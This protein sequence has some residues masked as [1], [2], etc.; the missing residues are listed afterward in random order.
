MYVRTVNRRL[1]C[2]CSVLACSS[3]RNVGDG[4]VSE[5][6]TINFDLGSVV[7]VQNFPRNMSSLKWKAFTIHIAS[8]T[9]ES[10]SFHCRFSVVIHVTL[11]SLYKGNANCMRWQLLGNE[12]RQ[13]H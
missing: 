13:Y 12:N 9:A 5:T 4:I 2:T 1:V 6:V 11:C 10:W 3:I 8:P 7:E